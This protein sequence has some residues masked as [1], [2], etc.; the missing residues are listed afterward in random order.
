MDPKTKQLVE[1]AEA[2]AKKATEGPWRT[3]GAS[4]DRCQCGM[5]WSIPL[6][7]VVLSGIAHDEMTN[8]FFSHNQMCDNVSF[9]AHARTDIPALCSAVR[10]QD[11]RAQRAEVERDAFG[12]RIKELETQLRE[13]VELAA[14]TVPYVSDYFR[15]KYE[16]NDRLAK[17]TSDSPSPEQTPKSP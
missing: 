4:E 10:E 5:I 8:S 3:C 15:D 16:M 6:D 9:A 2:R 1:E 13:A 7:G 12:E 14:E 17:L 11:R